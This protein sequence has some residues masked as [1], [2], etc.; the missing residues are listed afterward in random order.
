MLCVVLDDVAV[1]G[2]KRG[3][4]EVNGRHHRASMRR[5]RICRKMQTKSRVQE[6]MFALCSRG[7]LELAPAI[8]AVSRFLEIK[9]RLASLRHKSAQHASEMARIKSSHAIGPIA[10]AGSVSIG[11]KQYSRGLDAAHRQYDN[12]GTDLQPLSRLQYDFHSFDAII[13]PRL[14]Q[15]RAAN[16]QDG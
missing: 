12:V 8:H 1:F 14:A 15:T 11:R 13:S 16:A 4:R 2:N 3:L 7:K 6:P 10:K 9:R 5:I